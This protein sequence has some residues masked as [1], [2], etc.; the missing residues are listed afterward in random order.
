MKGS[1]SIGKIKGIQI[2]INYSWFLI[3][4]IVTWS[5]AANFFPATF[6][7]MTLYLRILLGAATA[8]LFFASVLLHELSHSLTA[9]R[10]NVPVRKISLVIFGGA[11]EIE[12]EPNEP[13]KELKIAVAGPIMSIF[14]YVVFTLLSMLLTTLNA[15][16]P[17]S[18]MFTYLGYVNLILAIFNLVP[19]FPLDGGRVLRALIWRFSGDLQKA[20]KLSSGLGS[21]FGYL[22]IVYGVFLLLNGAL[23]NGVWMVF[24]GWLIAQMSKS[25]YSSMVMSNILEKIHVSE[26]MN[27]NVVTVTAQLSIRALVDD[28]YFKYKYTVFPVIDNGRVSGIVNANAIKSSPREE[29]VRT[30][31]GSVMLPVN[32]SLIV[33]PQETVSTAMEKIMS[34]GVGRVLVMDK[35]TLVG[36]ISKTDILN[37]LG[38]YNQFNAR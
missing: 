33:A 37:Y 34:N 36:L 12:K 26:F 2:D 15:P 38:L 7:D 23:F 35:E 17:V 3:F 20:T 28:Y 8:L 16:E 30:P 21:V 29:W 22:L 32:D 24:I 1:F 27:K 31:I 5:M 25:S 10:L 14:L 13:M 11:A 19:A 4:I 9:I 18:V 6:P